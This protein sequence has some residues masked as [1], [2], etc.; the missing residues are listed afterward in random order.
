[1]MD[2]KAIGL[3]GAAAALAVSGK[4]LRPVAKQL[5]KGY[6]AVADATASRRAD[7]ARLHAEAR[8]EYR[9]QRQ[10]AAHASGPT[11]PESSAPREPPGA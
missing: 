3:L 4:G 9:A 7:L 8:D 1:M 5:M 11:A 6:V 2:E 10:A